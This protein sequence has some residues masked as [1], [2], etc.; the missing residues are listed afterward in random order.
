MIV[1]VAF[2]ISLQ[3]VT[4]IQISNGVLNQKSNKPIFKNF[5]SMYLYLTA[6]G[7]KLYMEMV[8][9]DLC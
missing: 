6:M 3:K 8:G 4:A 9:K 2:K 1:V 7:V 5:Q